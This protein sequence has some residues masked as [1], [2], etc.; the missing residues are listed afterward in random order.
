VTNSIITEC[1]GNLAARF[2]TLYSCVVKNNQGNGALQECTVWDSRIEGNAGRACQG[3]AYTRCEV[4]GN[5]GVYVITGGTF[6]NSIVRDNGGTMWTT[7]INC[8][9]QRNATN[10]ASEAHLFRPSCLVNCTVVS[11]TASTIFGS[12]SGLSSLTNCIVY[13]NMG[14]PFYTGTYVN[15]SCI[16]SNTGVVGTGNTTNAPQFVDP[17]SDDYRLGGGYRSPCVNKG[18]TLDWMINSVDLAG[19]PRVQHGVVDMGAYEVHNM[20]YG[21]MIAVK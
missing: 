21:T 17:A 12:Y 11:N 15:Y 8:L 3:Y 9:V 16:S 7:L 10:P 20:L 5:T 1:K 18:I 4:V 13:H 14:K 2:S 19:Q 6:T